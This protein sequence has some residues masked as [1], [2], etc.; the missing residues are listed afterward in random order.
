M[1]KEILPV[2]GIAKKLNNKAQALVE[3][4]IIL[5]IIIIIFFIIIDFSNIAYNRNHLEGTLDEV[6]ELVKND[7]PDIEK[8]LDNNTTYK[9]TSNNDKKT[10]KLTKEVTLITPFSNLFFSNPYKI[11]TERTI[12]NE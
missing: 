2:K 1:L 4:A 9:I 7:S 8:I 12:I 10:I 11:K 5:P 3:F 6:V